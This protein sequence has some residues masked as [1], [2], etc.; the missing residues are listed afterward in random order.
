MAMLA[1]WRRKR[2]APARTWT[3][4]EGS[5]LSLSPLKM[6]APTEA[7]P[8]AKRARSAYTI[9]PSQEEGV[10]QRG[11]VRSEHDTSR[12]RTLFAIVQSCRTVK[13]LIPLETARG[14][15]LLVPVRRVT[16]LTPVKP[17]TRGRVINLLQEG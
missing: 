14:A 5:V 12:A 10:A 17:S 16:L 11:A 2:A 15:M 4:P 6:V 1:P 7:C 13:L 9:V 3:P 8:V